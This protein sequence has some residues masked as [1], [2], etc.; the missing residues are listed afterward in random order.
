MNLKQFIDHRQHCPFCQADLFTAFHSSRKQYIRTEEHRFQTF[1]VLDSMKSGQKPYSVCYSFGLNHFDFRVEFY[2]HDRSVRYETA[3]DFLRT[4]FLELH[5]N[6][7]SFKFIRECGGCQRYGYRTQPFQLDLKSVRY[8]SL[9]LHHEDFGMM[10]PIEQGYRIYKL[11]NKYLENQSSLLI[12][13]GVP[14]EARITTSTPLSWRNATE[15]NLPLIPFVSEEE[16]TQ[17]L[18]NLLSFI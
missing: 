9:S 1:F 16:T 2:S 17:R 13:K 7:K 4:R 5:K 14:A 3:H 6:L 11:S 15:L 8:E 18:N 12:W 10:H